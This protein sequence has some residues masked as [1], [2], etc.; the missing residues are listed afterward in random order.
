M[1]PGEEKIKEFFEEKSEKIA[2]KI[3]RTPMEKF[4]VFFLILMTISSLALGYLQFKKNLQQPF[5]NDYLLIKRTELK[6]K[7]NI[8]SL[9]T[10]LTGTEAAQ[11]QQQDSDLDGLDD[12]SEI[13]IYKTSA[14][15][16]DTDGDGIWDKQEIINGTDPL[17]PQGQTCA[18]ETGTQNSNL[19]LNLNLPV[20]N[21]NSAPSV[22]SSLNDL[23]DLQEKI[24]TGEINLNELNIQDPQL[25]QILSELQATQNKDTSQLSPEE[26][27]AAIANLQNITAEQIR[28]ELINQGFDK[29]VLDSIDDP[30][31][32]QIFLETLKTAP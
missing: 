31:L 2:T 10:A 5:L 20:P 13:N 22:N 12:Y 19:N 17:C 26:K 15:L 16:E 32:K 6:E 7:Y 18:A 24:A 11:L 8:N 14:Y 1:L 29:N 27:Q 28:Q 25:Q 9:N 4:F 21:L 23:Y 3:E 30:T